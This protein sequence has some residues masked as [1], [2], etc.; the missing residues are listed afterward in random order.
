MCNLAI[1]DK[2]KVNEIWLVNLLVEYYY[3]ITRFFYQSLGKPNFDGIHNSS[4]QDIYYK[5]L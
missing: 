3:D 2:L 4:Y 1:I 5:F